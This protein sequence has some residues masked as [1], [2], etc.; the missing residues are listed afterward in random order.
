MLETAWFLIW[1]VLWAV[2]FML[3]GFDLGL[4]VLQP[5]L[6]KDDRD[7]K[8]V[9]LTMGP[10]WDGNE[11]WLVAAGGITFAAFPVLY[12]VMFSSFYSILMLIL[13]A[14]I[15][16]A[17]S[18]ELGEE[19]KGAV[20]KSVWRGCLA[21]GSLLP[22]FLF[23]IMFANIF[24]GIPIDGSGIY[25]GTLVTLLNPYALVGG[26]LFLLMFLL[27]GALWLAVKTDGPLQGR[28][29]RMASRIWLAL[30][31]T[32]A[33]FLILC[34]FQTE[35][36]AIY[37]DRPVLLAIPLVAV[38]ALLIT[39]IWIGRAEWFKA[40]WASSASIFSIVMFGVVGLYPLL[41]PSSLDN[42]FSLTVHNS[43]SSPLALK[44]TLGVVLVFIPII[45][46]YQ[47]WV[48]RFFGGKVDE[49]AYD[50]P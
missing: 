32:A 7:R 5:F 19:A 4:G 11:V 46:T 42:V 27:H 36:F 33:M 50:K 40:W 45:V 34:A 22:P 26:L 38:A 31:F 23:G 25:H 6:A 29:A 47:G 1:G 2:Y 8:A 20:W 18:I 14:L 48:Y 30:V 24:R 35:L 16:R 15:L 3:D 12:A 49:W 41:L 28:A 44:I 21:L 43:A 13:F 9:Y 10:F 17:V 39:R 37:L